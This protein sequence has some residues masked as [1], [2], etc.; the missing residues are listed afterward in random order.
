MK[1]ILYFV[2]NDKYFCS[3]RLGLAKKAIEEGYQ[4]ALMAKVTDPELKMQIETLGIKTF[5]IEHLSRSSFNPMKEMKL[6]LEIYQIYKR[7]KPDIVHHVAMKPVV[8][9]SIVAKVAK[10]PKVINA[11]GGLGYLFTESF[12]FSDAP[13]KFFKKSLILKAVCLL[14]RWISGQKNTVFILQNKDDIQTLIQKK[15]IDPNKAHLIRGSGV[16]VS[17][18]S[19]QQLPESEPIKIAFVSRMLW[20]KGVQELIDAAQ[21]L[22]EKRVAVE[23]Y[24]YGLPDTENPA[25]VPEAELKAWHEAGLIHWCGETKEVDKAY[26]NCHIAIL[27]SYR[28]GLP[29]SLLE[30]AACGR[31]IITTDVPGCREVVN[32]GE[33]GLLVPVKNATA[34]AEAILQLKN[35]NLQ[36]YGEK[37]RRLVENHFSDFIINQEILAIY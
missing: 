4:V 26:A 36:H 34:L 21:I 30:A 17:V 28:E 5:P 32:H 24:F 8:F 14:M 2:A 7:Y 12:S 20:D 25:S 1:K 29:K 11:L 35:D 19:P 3:H 13:I 37:G 9:G 31:A 33:N 22:K 15:C 16:D 18:F 23:F 6:L 27:P 10:V